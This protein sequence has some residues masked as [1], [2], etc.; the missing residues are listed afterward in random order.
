[1]DK[2][3]IANFSAMLQKRRDIPFKRKQ[4]NQV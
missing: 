3:K 4:Q 1:M 2:K